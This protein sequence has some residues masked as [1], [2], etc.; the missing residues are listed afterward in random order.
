[1]EKSYYES[2]LK[3]LGHIEVPAELRERMGWEYG[4][5]LN[6]LISEA[7]GKI[8][9]LTKDDGEIQVDNLG[10]IQL[11]EGSRKLLE[12]NENDPFEFCL[13]F[14]KVDLWRFAE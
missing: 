11:S 8:T 12:W 1:M 4:T 3:A 2:T 7:A 9:L 13:D 5:R 6:A 14:D 10:R